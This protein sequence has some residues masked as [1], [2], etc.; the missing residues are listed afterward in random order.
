L[1]LIYTRENP[2]LNPIEPVYDLE[3]ILRRTKEHMSDPFY[4]LDRRLSLP[5]YD[6]QSIDD[7]DFDALFEKTLI[8]SNSETNLDKIVFDHKTFQTLVSNNIPQAQ[9]PPRA[10]D[11]RF[12]PLVLPA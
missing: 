4:Y 12:S 8:S 6:A 1:K 10:M 7:L 11:F 9:N 2:D 5:K 3:K